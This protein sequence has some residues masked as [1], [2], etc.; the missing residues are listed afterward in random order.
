MSLHSE[1]SAR[2]RGFSGFRVSSVLTDPVLQQELQKGNPQ[3]KLALKGA[4]VDLDARL[5]VLIKYASDS[6]QE[7]KYLIISSYNISCKSQRGPLDPEA[8]YVGLVLYAKD[9]V[10]DWKA[11][12]VHVKSG[13]IYFKKTCDIMHIYIYIP[14]FAKKNN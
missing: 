12:G 6:L 7:N 9:G 8:D 2:P 1:P 11:N 14:S 5:G 10:T 13:Y 3:L 4:G